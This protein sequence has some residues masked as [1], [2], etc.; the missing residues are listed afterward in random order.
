MDATSALDCVR[1]RLVCC[2]VRPS[3]LDDLWRAAD[4][5]E[6]IHAECQQSVR[7]AGQL[8]RFLHRAAGGGDVLD[9]QVCAPGSWQS[10]PRPLSERSGPTRNGDLRTTRC[11]TTQP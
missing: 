6:L 1:A 9:D 10:G 2:R 3:T 11:L 4:A 7:F 5:P 8:Y